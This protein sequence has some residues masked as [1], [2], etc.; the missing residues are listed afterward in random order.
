MG[1]RMRTAARFRSFGIAAALIAC[2]ALTGCS[3]STL[4][5]ELDEQQANQVVAALMASGIDADKSQS[6]SKKGWE[7]SIARSDFPAAMQIL[8]ASG[9]PQRNS[10]SMMEIFKKDGFAS[11]ALQEKA[12]YDAGLEESIRQKL[13][14]VPGVVDAQ[15][16]IALPNREPLGGAAPDSSASVMI[17]QR[18]GANVADRET[19]LKVVIKDG[20]VGLNDVNKVTIKFFTIGQNQGAVPKV[21]RTG[22]VPA[23]LSSISPLTLAIAAGFVVLLALILAL[24]GRLRGKKPPPKPQA[25]VWNG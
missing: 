8:T 21:A 7:V 20:I 15:V 14:K 22:A 18:P 5:N 1:N 4:Y 11:S 2:L 19:D 12:L 10:L 17:F 16:S 25:P 3:K 6:T 23:A 9:L 24:S 13:L